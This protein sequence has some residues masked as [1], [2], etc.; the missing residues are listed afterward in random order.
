MKVVYDNLTDIIMIALA[1]IAICLSPSYPV[2]ESII[3]YLIGIF[4][5]I[6]YLYDM[7]IQKKLFTDN[8]VVYIFEKFNKKLNFFIRNLIVYSIYFYLFLFNQN[9]IYLLGILL[10]CFFDL[11]IVYGLI[12]TSM[13]SYFVHRMVEIDLKRKNS[14]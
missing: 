8:M 3:T 5:I 11:I 7:K 14:I 6:A 13:H 9:V 1:T 4:C 2:S 12:N 10:M